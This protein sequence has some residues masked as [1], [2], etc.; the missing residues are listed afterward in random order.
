MGYDTTLGHEPTCSSFDVDIDI[1]LWAGVSIIFIF[2]DTNCLVW[3]GSLA[4]MDGRR[5]T[6]PGGGLIFHMILYGQFS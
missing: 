6:P 5:N 2:I 3:F 1:K 4:G